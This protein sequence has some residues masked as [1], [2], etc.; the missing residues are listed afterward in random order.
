MRLLPAIASL[1]LLHFQF[2][3]ALLLWV[4]IHFFVAY[5]T[6][7]VAAFGFTVTFLLALVASAVSWLDS[8]RRR[9]VSFLGNLGVEPYVP[10]LLAASIIILLELILSLALT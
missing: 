1:R 9:E 6:G 4:A 2:L 3:R 8:L 5:G 7:E 10:A